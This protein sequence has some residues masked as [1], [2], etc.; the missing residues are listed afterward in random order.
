MADYNAGLIKDP[1][2]TGILLK[3]GILKTAGDDFVGALTDYNAYI[4][5]DSVSDAS[6]LA[7]QNRGFLSSKQGNYKSA[8]KDLDKA[9]S[10]FSNDETFLFRGDAKLALKDY[11]G[12]ADDYH[13]AV[14]LN[15]AYARA[16]AHSGIAKSYLGDIQ[17]V[18][19]DFAAALKA[20]PN[21]A[22]TYI[23]R[24]AAKVNMKDAAGAVA[25]CSLAIQLNSKNSRAYLQRGL[26]KIALNDKAGACADMNKALELG[27]KEAPASI[28]KYCK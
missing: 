20:E 2:N 6:A 19:E 17:G 3:R 22:D 1:K 10:I 15:P 26:A 25:D 5:I 24:G 8:M 11:A 16:L 27:S 9:V 23:D 7:Y 12:A 13:N 18:N 14:Y 28:A 4:K 21:N